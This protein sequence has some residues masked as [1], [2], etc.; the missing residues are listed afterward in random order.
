MSN[1]K[2]YTDQTPRFRIKPVSQQTGIPPITLRAWERRYQIL[3]PRREQNR[4]RLYSEV[5]IQS[6]KWLKTQVDMGVTI[7][8]A[9]TELRTMLAKGQPLEEIDESRPVRT[10]NSE[11]IAPNVLAERLFSSL[12]KH[13]ES[14]A[15]TVFDLAKVEFPLSKL[16]EEVLIPF[17]VR[18]GEGWFNG[19]VTISTEHF[20]STFLLTNLMSI[21]RKLPMR[22]NKA[23]ILVGGAPGELHVLGPLMMSILLREAGYFV[24][25]M[26]PD[27]PLEDLVMYCKDEKPKMVLISASSEQAALSLRGFNGML[28]QN[29][30]TP[31]FAYGGGAFSRDPTLLEKVPG[32]FLGNN[33]T[34]SVERV[35]QLI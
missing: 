4:Y 19:K 32:I 13:N 23:K 24:E 15:Q 35:K 7:S 17:L 6:L 11:Q 10:F 34:L 27:L 5:D 2:P 20:A 14:A 9:A 16:F 33:I 18:I 29:Q 26:G 25:F 30:Q 31:I 3:S 12:V 21:Y 1:S 22:K 28:A 8:Q